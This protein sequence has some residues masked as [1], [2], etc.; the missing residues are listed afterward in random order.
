MRDNVQ[1]AHLPEEKAEQGANISLKS[2][3]EV[4]MNLTVKDVLQLFQGQSVQ[5]AA[6]KA[7]LDRRVQS[8]NIMDAPDIWNW[9]KPG[10]LILTTAY[11]VKDDQALQ[12]RLIREL[13]V[14]G[15]AGLAVKTKRFL[16]EI[17]AVMREPADELG[18]PLLELPLDMSLAEIM[19]PI[20]SSIAAR[21]SY[22]LQRS[23]EI[24]KTL[25]KAAIKGGG[26]S[27]IIACLGSLTQYPVGCYDPSGTSLT[28]WL[29]ESIPGVSPETVKKLDELLAGTA[30]AADHPRR[31]LAQAKSP[32]VDAITVDG[33]QFFLIS[34]AIMSNNEYFGHISMIQASQAFMDI[35]CMALEHACTVAALDFLKQKAVAESRRLYSRDMLEHVLFGDLSSTGATE[36]LAASKL[37]QAKHFECVVIE[38]DEL[39]DDGN[40]AVIA[41]RLY[42]IAQQTITTKF[43]L[44]LVS[45]QTGKIIALMASSTPFDFRDTELLGKLHKALKEPHGSLKISVG[46]GTVAETIGA[47]RHSYHDALTCLRLGRVVKGIGVI[48]YPRDI[49]NYAM[50]SG[51]DTTRILAQVC[52]SIISK[53]GQ[54]DKDH[55]TELLKTLEVYLETDK[56]LTDTAKELYIHRNTLS[57]RLERIIDITGLD[58]TDRELT[59]SLR[60]VLRQSKLS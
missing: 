19:N 58:F 20:I 27:P 3:E 32:C 38:I 41:S 17:P 47:I 16:P 56:S 46:V 2:N 7:G 34:F 60:M 10:D 13:A 54:A 25:T 33:Q 35:N 12:E 55:A 48:T 14:R 24:H 15:C 30:I 8:V 18:F 57:N 26:L 6:G 37:I 39:E 11:T 51:A 40:T 31:S 59:F 42:K 9:V 5:L 52:G 50:L 22:L 43:P 23:N 29:P 1:N 36:A 49:V 21:Q 28:R 44:S 53:L 4:H 45:E